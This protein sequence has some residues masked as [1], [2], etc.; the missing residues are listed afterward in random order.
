MLDELQVT[1]ATGL[2]A[3]WPM[4]GFMGGVVNPDTGLT[5]A[6]TLTTWLAVRLLRRVH[7]RPPGA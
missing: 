1:V 7:R 3:L 6:Y 4:L 2:V 5:T